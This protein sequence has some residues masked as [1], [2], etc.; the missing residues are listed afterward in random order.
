MRKISDRP[1]SERAVVFFARLAFRG[2]YFPQVSRKQWLSLLWSNRRVLLSLC[3]EA[4]YSPRS[5][6]P[7]GSIE[8]RRE[9]A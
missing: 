5:A 4:F 6:P 1:L 8:A 7:P 9:I 2:I 3:Y